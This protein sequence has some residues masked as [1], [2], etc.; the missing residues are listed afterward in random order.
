MKHDNDDP[1]NLAMINPDEKL[2]LPSGIDGWVLTSGGICVGRVTI[3]GGELHFE[4]ASSG[5][6]WPANFKIEDPT[7]FTVP[8]INVED[9]YEHNAFGSTSGSHDV[10]G[11]DYEIIVDG[12]T[13]GWMK[14]NGSNTEWYAHPS[15]TSGGY[16]DNG[17]HSL[18]FVANTTG[19][20]VAAYKVVDGAL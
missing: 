16:L 4:W 19:G 11:C 20:S 15:Y 8:S 14:L 3:S 9:K 12:D 13:V 1:S 18:E 5:A 2:E 17:G 10:S 6:A 7:G